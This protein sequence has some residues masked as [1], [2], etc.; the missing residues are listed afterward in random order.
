AVCAGEG[1]GARVGKGGGGGGGERAAEAS[2]GG[3]RRDRDAVAARDPRVRDADRLDG[4]EQGA[5]RVE[6]HGT[7]AHQCVPGSPRPGSC[8]NWS[9]MPCPSFGW[10]KA[11]LRPPPIVASPITRSPSSRRRSTSGSRRSTWTARW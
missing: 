11:V 10:R 9:R 4:L 6:R 8:Q 3:V 2:L 1:G 7:E 5:G